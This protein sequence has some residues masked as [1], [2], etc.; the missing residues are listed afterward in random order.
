MCS[1]EFLYQQRST[2]ATK[3]T[4]YVYPTELKKLSETYTI[5]FLLHANSSF[6]IYKTLNDGRTIK[7]MYFI[8]QN[9]P[10]HFDV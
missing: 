4:R 8:N 6:Q 10:F 2:K 1:C 3:D 7:Y 5:S 9:V